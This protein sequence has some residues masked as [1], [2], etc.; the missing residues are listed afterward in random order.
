MKQRARLVVEWV[1]N[2]ALRAAALK[3]KKGLHLLGLST[4]PL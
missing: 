1:I 3:V 2:Q 4:S